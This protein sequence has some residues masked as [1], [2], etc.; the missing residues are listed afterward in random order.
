V[1][2]E[3]VG[4]VTEMAVADVAV[5]VVDVAA[6]MVTKKEEEEGIIII[7]KDVIINNNTNSKIEVIGR[8]WRNLS[9][10]F[11]QVSEKRNRN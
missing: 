11:Q 5:V 2:E 8:K 7:I 10:V 6:D 4:E 3:E 9:H 1:D